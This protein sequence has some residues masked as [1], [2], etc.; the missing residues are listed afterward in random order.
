MRTSSWPAKRDGAA[1][2]REDAAIEPRWKCASERRALGV[3]RLDDVLY[4]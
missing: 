2:S 4:E 3:E 1:D